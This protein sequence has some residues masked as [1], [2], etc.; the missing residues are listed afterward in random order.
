MVRPKRKILLLLIPGIVVFWVLAFALYF[1][2][3]LKQER[4]P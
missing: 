4:K 1:F 2:G 3:K